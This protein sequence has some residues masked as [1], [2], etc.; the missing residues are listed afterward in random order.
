MALE[1]KKP[2]HTASGRQELILQTIGGCE[3]EGKDGEIMR[4]MLDTCPCP[5]ADGSGVG[6]AGPWPLE[7]HKDEVHIH[8]SSMRQ[9][10]PCFSTSGDA[11]RLASQNY[12]TLRTTKVWEITHQT[13]PHSMHRRNYKLRKVKQKPPGLWSTRIST[14]Q[15]KCCSGQNSFWATIAKLEPKITLSDWEKHGTL[16][17]LACMTPL[18]AASGFLVD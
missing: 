3:Q 16:L 15:W 12:V 2:N 10:Y 14:G 8:P 7:S 13:Q 17:F 11:G 4:M 6:R 5:L 1:E 9:D 18:D